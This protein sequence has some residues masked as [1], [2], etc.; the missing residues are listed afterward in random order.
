V[1]ERGLVPV[2][3]AAHRAAVLGYEDVALVEVQVQQARDEPFRRTG[4]EERAPLALEVGLD[5]HHDVAE[6][7]VPAQVGEPRLDPAGVQLR[8]RREAAECRR[9]RSR[10]GP[11]RMLSGPHESFAH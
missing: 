2:D 10:F 9:L 5:R 3:D 11:S 6:R 1:A 4:A 8:P 7:L